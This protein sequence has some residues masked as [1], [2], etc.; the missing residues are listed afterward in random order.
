MNSKERVLRAVNHQ[1]VDRMPVDLG[2]TACSMVDEVYFKVKEALGIA[3]NI[4]PYRKGS[5][6]CYYD[7]RVLEKLG[8]DV[9]RVFARQTDNYPKY[10][11]DGTFSNEWGRCVTLWLRRRPRT[12]KLTIG[13]KRRK[14]WTLQESG[15]KRKSCTGKTSMPSLCGCPAMESLRLPAG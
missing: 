1:P 2:G 15:K 9:R 11:E 10:H 4:G 3:G 12:W 5:N 6:V 7:E 14:F 13:R 8:V